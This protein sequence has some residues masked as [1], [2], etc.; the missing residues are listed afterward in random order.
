MIEAFISLTFSALGGLS[1]LRIPDYGSS[2]LTQYIL[3]IEKLFSATVS[4]YLILAF[5]FDHTNLFEPHKEY[6]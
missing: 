5:C 2:T 4:F 6:R 3:K 1:N